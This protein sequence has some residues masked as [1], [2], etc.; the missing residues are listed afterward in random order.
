MS[1]APVLGYVLGIGIFAAAG[2]FL[3]GI[4]DTFID[5]G[6][7]QSND[8]LVFFQYIWT[9]VFILF[10]VFGGIYVIRQYNEKS[11]MGGLRR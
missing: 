2:W 1:A 8:V 5:V 6:M 7:H 9:A 4:K 3:N 10:L 11:Y